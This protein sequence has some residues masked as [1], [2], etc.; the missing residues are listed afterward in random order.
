M[1]RYRSCCRSRRA[2]CRRR[3]AEGVAFLPV[4]LTRQRNHTGKH[5][6][7]EQLGVGGVSVQVDEGV[8]RQVGH[9]LLQRGR[10]ELEAVDEAQPAERERHVLCHVVGDHVHP[11]G[12]APEGWRDE[13]GVVSLQVV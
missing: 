9:P 11:T 13:V 2:G 10:H 7:F 3:T 8:A 5:L 1:S 6:P 12:V 4:V